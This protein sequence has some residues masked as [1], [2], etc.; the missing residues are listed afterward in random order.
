[1][2]RLNAQFQALLNRTET[3]QLRYLHHRIN[4]NNRLIALL[5]GR[6]VGKTTLLLQH[7]KLNCDKL[8]TLYLS[9]D[10]FYFATNSLFELAHQFHINGGNQ[11]FIDEIHKYPNWSQEIKMMYDNLPQLKI[12][13]TGSSVLDIYKGTDDLSRR[14]IRYELQGLSFREYLNLTLGQNIQAYTLSEILEHQV[15]LNDVEFPLMHFKNYLREGYYPF[16]REPD[17]HERLTNVLNMTIETDIP[18]YARMNVSTALKMKLLLSIIARSVPFKPNFSKISELIGVHRNQIVE[19]LHY[20]EKAGIIQQI[21]ERS[22]GIRQLGKVEKIYLDNPNLMYAIGSNATDTGNLR[23]TFFLNQMSLEHVVYSHSAGDF[24]IED[25]VFEV[26]GRTKTKKQIA[27]ES[28][29]YL[30]K[31]DIEYGYMNT[32]PLWHFGMTY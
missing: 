24:Q 13:V 16:W 10:D 31:D 22:G 4:W 15:E 6:G 26:G 25:F 30:V 12:V 23:E 7:I 14:V 20:F 28:N 18:M 1:M 5:G 17:Y 11:L 19:F 21:R 3:K 8:Y 32:L 29:A 2:E 27:N 9:A